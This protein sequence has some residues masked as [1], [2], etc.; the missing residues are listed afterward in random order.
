MAD[1]SEHEETRPL[2]AVAGASG[3][4]GTHLRMRLAD[5]FRFRALTRSP[6]IAEDRSGEDATAWAPC[7]L[8]S[9]PA[10]TEALR[11]CQHAFY[12]VHSMAPSSRMVQSRFADMDL[13]LADNFVRGAEAAGVEHIVYLSGLLPEG[14]EPLSAH[15]ASRQEVEAAL[16]SRSVA[17]TVVRAGLIFGPGGSSFRML[18]NLVR[19]LPVMVF[20]AW[21]GS[22]TQ[23]IDIE[24]VCRAFDHCLSDA[25]LKGG[26]YDLA[27][28]ESMAYREVIQRTGDILN[29]RPAG[30]TVP[31]NCFA[32]SARWVALFG[33]VS[34]AL[35]GPLQESLRHDLWA[36]DNPLLRRLRPGLV[37]FPT[38][39][40]KAVDASGRPLPNPR[41]ASAPKDRRRIKRGRRVRSLQRMPLPEGWD[42]AMVED[43]YGRWLSRRFGRWMNVDRDAL[44]VLRFRVLGDRTVLLELTPTPQTR[45]SRRR[46]A[47]YISGGWLTRPSDPPGRFEFRV[48]PET[49]CL[50]AAIHGFCPTL[51]WWLYAQTQARVHLAV[52]RAF[53]RHLSRQSP[54]VTLG[55][56]EAANASPET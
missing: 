44:G 9:L 39:L 2:V 14:E 42:A 30:L 54:V 21:V 26:T 28:H 56:A 23:T 3:F 32:L 8:F 25:D 20:P 31:V 27:G 35:V 34:L 15:L 6:T 46:R 49:G 12:L 11:G 48:F 4:V 19:R 16:R 1:S 40:R 22:T 50:I 51:P 41:A 18:V 7:D 36:R 55:G 17:V 24:D 47:F 5:R 52:M 10:V 13:V 29:R 38:S 53:S 37:D 33:G 43:A 45:T